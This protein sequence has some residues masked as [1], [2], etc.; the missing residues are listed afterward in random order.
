MYKR[1]YAKKVLLNVWTLCVVV[2]T[3]ILTWSHFHVDE[4]VN[5]SSLVLNHELSL[6]GHPSYGLKRKPVC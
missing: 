5:V 6:L 2:S 1:N 3:V 4:T